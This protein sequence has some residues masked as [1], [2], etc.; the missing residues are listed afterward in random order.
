MSDE[1]PAVSSKMS[2]M[3]ERVARGEESWEDVRARMKQSAEEAASR[4]G[5]EM[6]LATEDIGILRLAE[7]RRLDWLPGDVFDGLVRRYYEP[8]PSTYLTGRSP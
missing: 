8:N 3:L 5:A 7:G 6:S 1:V 2:V 4:A